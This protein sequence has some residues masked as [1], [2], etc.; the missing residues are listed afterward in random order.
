[1]T[2]YIH[3]LGWALL[4]SLWQGAIL[5]L[6]YLILRR[7]LRGYKPQ[8]RYTLALGCQL[9]LLL[10]VG[11]TVVQ[12][13]PDNQAFLGLSEELKVTIS[14]LEE[15][16]IELPLNEVTVLSQGPSSTWNWRRN[17]ESLAPYLALAW[18]L[19]IALMGVRWGASLWQLHLLR[20]QGLSAGPVHWQN[21]LNQISKKWGLP[22]KVTLLVSSRITSPATLGFFK[23]VIL[24]PVSVVTGLSPEQWEAIL[25]HEL[26]H[27]RRADYVVRLIQS[28]IEI[29][30]FYHPLIWWVG[31]DLTHEREACCDDQA[32][33]ACGDALRYAH[34]LTT[35]QRMCQPS[36]IQ[37]T[38][39]IQSKHQKPFTRR[40]QRLFEPTQA[41]ALRPR[42]GF[43]LTLMLMVSMTSYG[44]I[45]LGDKV[46]PQPIA[47]NVQQEF[48]LEID[49]SWTHDQLKQEIKSLQAKGITLTLDG[50]GNNPEGKL[51]FLIGEI[52]FPDGASQYF[53]AELGTLT[54]DRKEGAR[55]RVTVEGGRTAGS[56]DPRKSTLS[57]IES[58]ETQSSI[59]GTQST[60]NELGYAL[61]LENER[62]DADNHLVEADFSLQRLPNG[63]VS[64][65]HLG[66]LETAVLQFQR[67]ARRISVYPSNLM[68]EVILPPSLDH[69]EEAR[70]AFLDFQETQAQ[71]QAEQKPDL[72]LLINERWTPAD[73]KALTEELAEDEVE[74][75]INSWLTKP[76]GN[77]NYLEGS[78]SL[79]NGSNASFSGFLGQISITYQEGEGLEVIVDERVH[80][81]GEIEVL[82]NM[83]AFGQAMTEPVETGEFL[84]L[85]IDGSWTMERLEAMAPE[86]EARGIKIDVKVHKSNPQ[87]AIEAMGGFI[88]LPGASQQL[89]ALKMGSLTLT[90]NEEDGYELEVEPGKEREDIHLVIDRSW[91]YS[92]L[93]LASGECLADGML[94][95]P[96]DVTLEDGKLTGLKGD[97]FFPGGMSASTFSTDNLDQVIIKSWVKPKDGK[98]YFVRVI[99]LDEEE[100]V[101]EVTEEEVLEKAK[102]VV[103]EPK[104][105]K[106]ENLPVVE[107]YH[108]VPRIRHSEEKFEPL[109]IINGKPME[110]S[111]IQF[112][113][114]K[115]IENITVIKGEA[116]TTKYGEE[117]AHGVIEI[118]TKRPVDFGDKL[119]LN[120]S[121]NPSQNVFAIDFQLPEA[122]SLTIEIYDLQ[123]KKVHTIFDGYKEIGNHMYFWEGGEQPAGSYMIRLKGETVFGYSKILLVD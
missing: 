49:Q 42:A 23:P 26:A 123:G 63:W 69:D 9:A 93:A 8:L 45:N 40:I 54:I 102:I 55:V 46:D 15:A 94:F 66:P 72:D 58:G 76:S 25:L 99:D 57:F 110:S 13:W 79:P 120:V 35:L 52:S 29:L 75:T 84:E 24:I 44:W 118:K 81:E 12:Y 100:V 103:G 91:D 78:I 51:A 28:L 109:F 70:Q 107:G 112:L 18:L 80:D 56:A 116:A 119:E 96:D 37:L 65:F 68:P 101:E 113:E 61:T 10:W 11:L 50:W 2:P 71:A 1:M 95:I 89:F 104:V 30:F 36:N 115:E 41:S 7:A 85:V 74:L 83:R 14:P 5:A 86:L 105:V 39:A 32:V 34:A 108:A 97:I 67:E 21:Q 122:Q 106:V 48:S 64:D 62:Y 4:H 88:S 16:E 114:P 111:E 31:R 33:A 121:P 38:M 3:T 73:L 20:T 60:L 82:D 98:N 87:G 43:I 77:L 53:T 117:G 22:R 6:I 17:L 92:Q 27:I 19:G 90:G 47:E 59:R